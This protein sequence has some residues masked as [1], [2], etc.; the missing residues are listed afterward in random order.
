MSLEKWAKLSEEYGNNGLTFKYALEL[1][2][3]IDADLAVSALVTNVTGRYI[4]R[5]AQNE[6]KEGPE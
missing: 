1:I 2:P 6:R 4:L 3:I 5:Q